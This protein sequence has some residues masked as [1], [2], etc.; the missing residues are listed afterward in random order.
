MRYTL[1]WMIFLLLCSAAICSLIQWT[2]NLP[3]DSESYF[4]RDAWSFS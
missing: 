4:E 2:H 1:T 3:I